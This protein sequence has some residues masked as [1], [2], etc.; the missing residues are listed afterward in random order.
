M[1]SILRRFLQATFSST[2]EQPA[3][4]LTPEQDAAAL[5]DQRAAD[6]VVDMFTWEALV[7]LGKYEEHLGEDHPGTPAKAGDL[8]VQCWR[9]AGLDLAEWLA[10]PD[11]SDARM[12]LRTAVD[13][14]VNH[15][16]TGGTIQGAVDD[17]G[18]N[19]RQFPALTV[20]E[21]AS[22]MERTYGEPLVTSNPADWLA[23]SLVRVAAARLV[24]DT[25]GSGARAEPGSQ[26]HQWALSILHESELQGYDR[27]ESIGSAQQTVRKVAASWK[28]KVATL[29]AGVAGIAGLDYFVTGDVDQWTYG[30]ATAVLFAAHLAAKHFVQRQDAHGGVEAAQAQ[31]LRDRS[32]LAGSLERFGRQHQPRAP[33]A[34]GRRAGGVGQ[35]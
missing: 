13:M 10:E 31:N 35:R 11:P 28:V 29:A 20:A 23:K 1:S 33:G 27:Q 9:D 21:V 12:L 7:A 32:A 2:A 16:G 22:Q 14:A 3:E 8:L 15:P 6:E 26:A 17:L 4:P 25:V 18:V 24:R 34:G 19:P 30:G 5:A